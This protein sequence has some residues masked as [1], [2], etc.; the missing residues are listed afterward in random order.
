MFDFSQLPTVNACLNTASTLCLV[1][2]YLMIRRGAK[3]AHKTTMTMAV[4]FSTAFLVSYLVYHF[5]AGSVRYPGTGTLRTLY[6]SILLTHTILAASVPILAA[7]TLMHALRGRFD[8]HRAIARWTLP[9][10]LYVS[11]TGVVIYVMLYQLS[12]LP[13]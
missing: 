7:I 10:W 9:I 6:L 2:G 5:Q 1:Y 8:R 12:D 11:I 3:A 4:G 13:T